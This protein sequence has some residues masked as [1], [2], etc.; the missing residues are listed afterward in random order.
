MIYTF[1]HIWIHALKGVY[2]R[3]SLMK[4]GEALTIVQYVPT[5]KHSN[6]HAHA[7]TQ[8]CTHTHTHTYTHTRS[9]AHT[10][11]RTHTCA[12]THT[13]THSC[14]YRYWSSFQSFSA[15]NY[16]KKTRRHA[17][18]HTRKR[19]KLHPHTHSHTHAKKIIPSSNTAPITFYCS[20]VSN[21]RYTTSKVG[22]FWANAG[23]GG[24]WEVGLGGRGGLIFLPARCGGF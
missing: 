16:F 21:T 11:I 24:Q 1:K 4:R 14:T 23:G 12:H 5:Y 15:S 22:G 3:Q 13:H 9:R 17:H 10:Y 8:A 2:T 18:K 7:N 6:T 20:C 19:C